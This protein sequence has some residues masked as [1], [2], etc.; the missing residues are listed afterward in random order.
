MAIIALRWEHSVSG[1]LSSVSVSV[2][3]GRTSQASRRPR[4][5]Q[6]G[7]GIAVSRDDLAC[8][9]LHSLELLLLCEV[10]RGE[11]LC[12]VIGLLSEID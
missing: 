11:P 3:S 9:F 5:T 1:L 8:P 7:R 4:E 6:C 10:Q 12:E 2:H